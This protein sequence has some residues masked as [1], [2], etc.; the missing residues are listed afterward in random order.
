MTGSTDSEG[1]IRSPLNFDGYSGVSAWAYV[2]RIRVCGFP[3]AA[4]LVVGFIKLCVSPRLEFFT[5]DRDQVGADAHWA[6]EYSCRSREQAAKGEL[7]TKRWVLGVAG[8]HVGVSVRA[9]LVCSLSGPGE[10][11]DA[12]CLV[13]GLSWDPAA[14]SLP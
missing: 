13:W 9:R 5:S 8:G 1:V 2:V 6:A 14:W 10:G 12:G 3:A 4:V 11:R 7:W